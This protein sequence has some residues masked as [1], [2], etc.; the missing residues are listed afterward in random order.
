MTAAFTAGTGIAATGFTATCTASGVSKTATGTSSPLVVTGLTAMTGYS[1]TV[2]AQNANGSSV[3]SNLKSA[4]TTAAVTYST[5]ANFASVIAT[6]YTPT[7]LTASGTVTNRARYMISDKSTAGTTSNYLS[8]GSTY[9]A[10]TGY[11]VTSGTLLTAAA[12]VP[13][14]TYNDYLS[15]TIQMVEIGTGTGY[16]RLDSHLHPN[17]SIDVDA[18]DNKLN[19]RNNFGKAAITSGYVTFSYDAVKHLLKAQN[20]YSYS[21]N[22]TTYVATY[23]LATTYTNQYVNYSGGIYTLSATGTPLYLYGTPLSLGIPEFMNPMKVPFVTNGAAPFLTKV[24][25]TSIEGTSGILSKV[26]STYSSQVATAGTNAATKTAAD[27]LLATIQSTLVTNGEKLR[28]PTAVYTAY[29]DAALATKLV[30]DSVAD[31]APGQNLVPYV[32]FTNEFVTSTSGVKTYHPFMV[33]VSYGNQ[34]SPNGLKDI[35]HPPG[36]AGMAYPN[37]TVTRYS[38]LENYIF[39]IPMKD[40]GQVTSVIT[41][42]YPSTGSASASPKN[43]WKDI[44][45]P[46]TAVLTPNV[47]TWA[48]SADNGILI[49]GAVIFPTFNN[50]LVPSHLAGELS[51]SGCHVGQGGGGPHCHADGYQS[52]QGLGFYNDPDYLGKTHPPLLGFGYDGVAL[53]G[54]YRSSDTLVLGYSTALDAFGGHNHDSIGYHYHAH[55]VANYAAVD[56]KG[57]TMTSDLHVLM[58]GAYIGSTNSI[59]FFRTN[60]SFNNNKYMGG[61]VAP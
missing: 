27:A 54:N 42:S 38:N 25:V 34:A 46:W 19:F 58:K 61:T 36:S 37:A 21:Y 35:P 56:Q 5:P 43:L 28:Y 48:D 57:V 52:G 18:T 50:V 17:N 29:R 11:T 14:P 53:F 16:Y 47:Y 41:N 7:A 9:S 10:T 13:E 6:S 40:Y 23:T 31:G 49:N 15:K 30:S 59:P 8:I 39:M 32:Y 24:T 12:L 3:A 20:R 33:V 2:I 55:T 1:C 22:A 44:A 51:A 26:K 60:S 4:T 45:S